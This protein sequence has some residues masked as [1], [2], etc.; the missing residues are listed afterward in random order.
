ME[1]GYIGRIIRNEFDAYDLNNVP[2]M[3]NAGGQS[4]EQAWATL[5]QQT[6][7]GTNPAGA[8]PQPFFQNTINAN[9]SYCAGFANCT[10]AFATQEAP[11]IST[12]AVWQAW[13]DVSGSLTC[14]GSPSA[15]NPWVPAFRFGRSMLNDPFINPA[16]G[17]QTLLGANG[18]QT[19]AFLN[20]STGWGNYNAAFL[21]L[22]LQDWH[23]LTMKTNLTYSKSLGTQTAVQ[24]SSSITALNPYNLSTSYGVQPFDET[25]SYNL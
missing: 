17:Q 18:Q 25:W 22:S 20:T 21:Q 12:A 14:P 2:Y 10:A 9:S 4:F 7:L 3:M 16:T 8:T 24:A 19:D 13:Q 23:G 6:A 15:A 5:S 1:V 11:N